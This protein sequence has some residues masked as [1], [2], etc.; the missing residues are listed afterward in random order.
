MY[1]TDEIQSTVK[2]LAEDL[3]IS[4]VI[5]VGSYAKNKAT[6]QSDIDLVIDGKDLSES[7]WDFLFRLEDAFSAKVDLITMRGLKNSCMLNSILSGGVVL[8][9]E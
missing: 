9:E 7:Y 3:P 8:Y 1:N 4:K 5:L 2:K 6:A